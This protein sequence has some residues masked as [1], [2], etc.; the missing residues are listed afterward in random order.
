[1]SVRRGGRACPSGA[2]TRSCL[3]RV[4]QWVVSN[5]SG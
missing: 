5:L 2:L 3:N 4:A 1:M